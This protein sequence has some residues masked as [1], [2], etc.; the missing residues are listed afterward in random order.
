MLLENSSRN[1]PPALLKLIQQCDRL[2]LNL[3]C[4]DPCTS[5]AAC[6]KKVL[7]FYLHY[8]HKVRHSHLGKTAK[9]WLSIIDHTKLIL[10]LRYT[11][12]PITLICFANVIVIWLTFFYFDGSNDSRYL[13]RLDVFLTNIDKTHPWAK[14]T[15][16]KRCY[17]CRSF[18]PSG[19]TLSS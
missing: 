11:V 5:M 15:A 4:S 18:S 1:Y 13:L 9:F 16:S 3:V 2:T 14:D 17:C 8:E 7:A 12:K 19:I 6:N 10:M